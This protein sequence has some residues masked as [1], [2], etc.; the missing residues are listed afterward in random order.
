MSVPWYTF[1]VAVFAGAVVCASISWFCLE[2][3]ALRLK[4]LP[5]RLRARDT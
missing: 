1:V 3:P 5:R 2:R 4:D